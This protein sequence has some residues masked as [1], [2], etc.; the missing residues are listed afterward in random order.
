MRSSRLLRVRLNIT[1]GY[2]EGIVSR[3]LQV[4]DLW[5]L[6]HRRLGGVLAAS[7]PS[8]TRSAAMVTLA[9][10]IAAA[11]AM[12]APLL[13]IQV[14]I[15]KPFVSL[16]SFNVL[17]S[18]GYIALFASAISFL[19]WFEAY[20]NWSCTG[21]TIPSF[22]ADFRRWPGILRARRRTRSCEMPARYWS[23]EVSTR[24]VSTAR[25]RDR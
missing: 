15:I 3:G 22:D 16:A 12:M 2:L 5:M 25:E 6:P 20:P 11:L 17:L 19:F 1:R 18:I 21:R 4:G 24:Q 9:A 14:A 23:W 10:S 7:A 8:S 13:I